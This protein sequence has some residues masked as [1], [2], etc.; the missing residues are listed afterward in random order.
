MLKY[1]D[2]YK[3]EKNSRVVICCK[4]KSVKQKFSIHS[5]WPENPTY[6]NGSLRFAVITRCFMKYMFNLADKQR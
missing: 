6:I 5:E 1:P 4:L 3:K 2:I